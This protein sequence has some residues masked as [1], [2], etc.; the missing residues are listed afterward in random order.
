MKLSKLVPWR[1]FDLKYADNFRSKKGQRAIDSRMALGALLIKPAYKALSDEDIT[2]EIAMNPYLQY[3]LGLHEYRYE[4]PFDPSMM[5]RF[6]QRITP[7]MLAWVN[8]QI[9]GRKSEQ[10]RNDDSSD[11]DDSHTDGGQADECQGSKNEEEK[12]EGTMILDATCAPQNIRFPTDASLLNEAREKAEEIIDDLHEMGLSEGKKPRTYR[13]KARRKYN[14][15]SKTRKKTVKMIRTTIRQQLGYLSRDL[16]FIDAYERRH[17]GCLQ[18]LSTRKQTMLQVIRT[19]Y[20]QQEYMYRTGTHKV[21]DRIVSLSQSWVRPIVRGKQTADVEFGAKVEM[22]VVDGFLRIED[23]RWD[24]FNESTTLQ[25]SVEAYRKAY[26]YYP[27]RVLADTIFRTRENLKYCKERGIH[28]NGPKLGKPF[29]DPAEAKRHKKLEWLESGD[30]GE[31]ERNFGVGKRR[32]SLDCIVTKLKETS[33]VMIHS[34]VIYMNLRKRL[35]LLLRSF[36]SRLR[37]M[38]HIRL[39]EDDSA[40]A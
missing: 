7:E 6:R 36:F 18:K 3:F 37:M 13:E 4:C 15:F 11:N 10:D 22:S 17:P 8:D 12:N 35:R 1:E 23:L 34:I 2:K 16:G 32:Y 19:L 26:G 14:S 29:A 21:P 31:I 28:L 20:S 33:E 39:N 24:A 40:L 9:D 27:A 25:Q 5:T 38:L 30:R